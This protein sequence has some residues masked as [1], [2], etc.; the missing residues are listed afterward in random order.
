M[1]TMIAPLKPLDIKIVIIAKPDRPSQNAA[2]SIC[3]EHSP[4]SNLI[5]ENLFAQQ[6]KTF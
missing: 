6:P 4:Y 5:L 1:P 3:M 2:S